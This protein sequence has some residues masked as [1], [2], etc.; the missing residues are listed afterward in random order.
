MKLG[1][2]IYGC[3]REFREDPQA[4]CGRLAAAGYTQLEPCV[5]L[6]RT[7]AQLLEAGMNPV[8][9][10]EETA[11]FAALMQAHGLALSSCHIFGS[12]RA[13]AERAA[14]LAAEN[15]LREIV[16]GFPEGDPAE[17]W[18]AFAED[19]LYLAE[20]LKAVGAELG[21]HNSWP[22][23]RAKTDDGRSALER[24]LGRCAGRVGT[25]IDVG[26]VLYGGED[27]AA[28]ME[29]VLPYLRSVHYKDMKPGYAGLPPTEA[30]TP[31]GR[32]ALDWRAVQAFAK[33][34]GIPE[35]IDQDMSTGDFLADLEESAALL[36]T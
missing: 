7:A 3:M 24:V 22:E 13:D 35:L 19:C 30:H 1:V 23:I 5:S 32:G 29:R 15:D 26:W 10:P 28:Y 33:A 16:V 14:V 9:Q 2:Q 36:N 18:P 21:I 6:N 8:W 34:H 20:K 31:L 4:F 11:G 27:P 17:L 25:Q 12:L